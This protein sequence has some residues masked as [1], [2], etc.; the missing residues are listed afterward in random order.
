M[1]DPHSPAPSRWDRIK[2]LVADALE[3]DRGEQRAYLERQCA[4]DADLLEAAWELLESFGDADD[5]LEGE[6]AGAWAAGE[7]TAGGGPGDDLPHRRLEGKRLGSYEVTRFLAAGG[8]GAVYEATHLKTG[9]KVALKR[10]TESISPDRA[11]RFQREVETLG[12]L[13]HEAIAQVLDA[14]LHEDALGIESPYFVLELVNGESLAQFAAEKSERERLE[15]VTQ[16]CDGV[17]HAHER[18]VVHRDLK[19]DNILVTPEGRVKILDFGI[20]RLLSSDDTDDNTAYTETGQFL[21]TLAYMSPEQLG[22]RP[23]E[24]D[25]RC[26]VYALGVILYELLAK[27][28]PLDPRGRPILEAAALIRDVDPASLSS[29]DRSYRGDLDTIVTKALA[30]DKQRRYDTVAELADDIRRYLNDEPISARPPT[31]WYQLSKFA[32]RNR[33]LC[34]SI[35]GALVLLTLGVIG[36]GYGYLEAH[37]ERLRVEQERDRARDAETEAK[38]AADEA[39]AISDFLSQLLEAADPG[40]QGRDAKVSE[41]LAVAG[42]DLDARFANQPVI[43]ARLHSV[44]GWTY[45]S[46]G[47]DEAAE[48]HL[49]RSIDLYTAEQGKDAVNTIETRNRWVQV[50]L[51]QDDLSG[52]DQASNDT[53]LLARAALGPEHSLS[54]AAL[55]NRALYFQAAGEQSLAEKHFAEAVEG[56]RDAAK[57][58]PTFLESSLNNHAIL[59]SEGGKHEAAVATLRELVTVRNTRLGP[60]HL[61]TVVSTLNLAYALSEVGQ[62]DES[63]QLFDQWLPVVESALGPDHPLALSHLQNHGAVLLSLGQHEESARILK[64]VYDRQ[65][66]VLGREHTETLTTLNNICVAFLYLERFTDAEPLAEELVEGFERSVGTQHPRYWQAAGTLGNVW[67]KLEKKDEARQLIVKVLEGQQGALGPEHPQA[68]ITQNNYAQLLRDAGE[69]EQAAAQLQLV[70][71]RYRRA[72]P[73]DQRSLCILQFNYGRVLLELGQHEQARIEL[74]SAQQL[75]TNSWGP[76]HKQT[77]RVAQLLATIPPTNSPAGAE[78]TPQQ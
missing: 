66:Q 25:G 2:E 78:G 55:A 48:R 14:G 73:G 74:E 26:D 13:Q 36:T 41:V 7:T 8:M 3:R 64:N 57:L 15:L 39:R 29:V 38:A 51:R 45:H 23:S 9:R 59:L 30:K 4:G 22:G 28:L 35:A 34:G 50:L 40:R 1:T 60:T 32:R 27:R 37:R 6:P 54:W 65:R 49:R 46:L 17:Q 75:G 63:L 31:T 11:R 43:A 5:F 58:D 53:L 47:D 16:V 18:G 71:E 33:W 19:P 12:R 24:I 76:D 44:I 10:M 70:V 42:A 67:S 62:T 69:R 56:L 20:A 21:G 68:I 61:S 52:A 77:Q 72:V